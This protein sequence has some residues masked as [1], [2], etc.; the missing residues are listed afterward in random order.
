MVTGLIC[1]VRDL[2][3]DTMPGEGDDMDVDM[4]VR[5]KKSTLSLRRSYLLVWREESHRG[6]TQYHIGKDVL[7]LNR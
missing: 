3:L 2:T 4:N 1:L 6:I 5:A 7:V